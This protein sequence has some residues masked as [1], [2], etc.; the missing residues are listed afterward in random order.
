MAAKFNPPSPMDFSQPE[1]WPAWRARFERYRTITKLDKESEDRQ[2]STVLYCMGPE[3]EGIFTALDL[4]EEN[5]QEWS[6]VMAA[7]DAYFQP[8]VNVIHQRTIF[9]SCVQLAGESVEEF[10]RRLRAA[11]KY[12]AFKDADERIRDRLVAHMSNRAVSK[13]LQLISHD[14]LTLAV[15]IQKAR[16][17]E[18]V[19]REVSQQSAV[20]PNLSQTAAAV[21]NRSYKYQ[22][23]QATEND[24]R[25]HQFPSKCK[26]CGSASNHQNNRANCP[27]NGRKCNACGKIGHFAVVCL[28]HGR[29]VNTASVA[30]AHSNHGDG[31]ICTS[32]TRESDNIDSDYMFLG[33][34]RLHGTDKAWTTTLQISGTPVTFKIDTGADVSI[35]AR[36]TYDALPDAPPLE[37]SHANLHGPGGESL[38]VEGQ[39]T[40]MATHRSRK[41][42]LQCV[43]I[44]GPANSNLLSRAMSL[45]MGVVKLIS[46]CTSDSNAMLGRMIG[47]PATIHLKP[48]AVPYNCVTAR[49]VP[50][51]IH[52]KVKDELSRMQREGVIEP[53]TAPTD[54]C[55]PIVPVVKPNGRI[56]IC[57]DLKRLNSSVMREHYPLPTVDDTLAKLRGAKIFTTLDLT[58][59]FW[60]IP[61]AD[62]CVDLTTFITP[63]GRFRF[64]RLPFGIT[65]APEIFQRRLQQLMDDIPNVLVF[66]D[67]IIVFGTTLA[68]HDEALGKVTDRLKTAGLTLNDRKC[69]FR[70]H[71]VKFLGH[72]VSSSGVQPDAEKLAAIAKLPAPNDVEDLRRALGLFTFLAKFLP[73]L[74]TVAAPLR[75]LLRK[76]SIWTWGEPEI[77]AFAKLKSLAVAAPCLAFYDPD[78][79]TRVTADASSY[80]VGGALVQLQPDTNSWQPVAYASR[81]LSKAEQR[82]AQLEKELLASVWCCEHFRQYLYGGRQFTI[83]TDHKPLVPLI[84]TR[85]L[86]KVPIRCQRLLIRLLRYNVKAEYIPGRDLIV[87]DTL[88]RAPQPAQESQSDEALYNESM[89]TIETITSSICSTSKHLEIKQATQEDPILQRVIHST[90]HGWPT[91]VAG[92]L[93]PYYKERGQL[94]F[95]EGVLYHGLR[96]VIPVALQQSTLEVIHKGHQ[97]IVKCKARAQHSVWWPKISQS[98]ETFVTQ[99]QTCSIQRFQPPE[100]LRP[101][102]FPML[103]WQ[104]IAVDLFQYNQH[105]YLVM[106][107]YFS[108]FIHV[109]LLHTTTSSSVAKAMLSVFCIHGIPQEVTSDNGPQFSSS[110]FARFAQVQG[111][112]HITSS[113]NHP[114]GNGEAERAVQTV[115]RLLATNDN[116]DEALLQ[117]RSTPI[118]NGYSP[119]ELIFGRRIRTQIPS[120]DDQLK[121]NWPDIP[122]VR[123][124]ETNSKQYQK[125]NHDRAHR[126]KSLPELSPGTTVYISD[127]H[128]Q[129]VV[130]NQ[131]DD[132]SYT[133][134]ADGGVYRRNRHSLVTVPPDKLPSTAEGNCIGDPSRFRLP[135]AKF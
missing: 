10:V 57:V 36:S 109:C 22:P 49:K 59:G 21:A 18:Q 73:E 63:F 126:A 3:A 71:E 35:M 20:D 17:T 123:Q 94:S 27:A 46:S 105:V 40:T 54:W 102:V 117:Y 67:D 76:D 48:D 107:D 30:P 41:Y 87:A 98:I 24:G 44:E 113:P 130:E 66:I 26:W 16:Q 91:S 85:D 34:A 84:N 56:R 96:L 53:V 108:R 5:S 80:G 122:A 82:Y 58:S 112:T 111:F 124:Q 74:A 25:V 121:P 89:A 72:C 61:L 95:H 51:P 132:K 77:E 81:T 99:C 100:P 133:V 88:S 9:E 38:K 52:S 129:A 47:K 79:A 125:E 65:S 31:A 7:L 90:L 43:V 64:K 45:E 69:R 92:E 1:S 2:V 15:A 120:T 14:K 78:A 104:H 97:G 29:A 60:Q 12:C 55:A 131:L 128:K 50:I 33:M 70:Q 106:V 62:D 116:L 68:K 114:K 127:Q 39:F 86:D 119:A 4:S 110:E 134:K 93:Q 6:P 11:A 101:S 23:R 135:R 13:E 83:H 32:D 42:M 19:T 75:R 103:P 8:S 118:A 37:P 28:K 115:K